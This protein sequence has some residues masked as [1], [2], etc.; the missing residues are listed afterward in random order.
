MSE[1]STP[2]PFD[3]ARFVAAQ[4]HDYDLA[5]AE[6]VRGRKTGHWIWYI[7]PQ[8]RGLGSSPLSWHYGITSIDEARAYLAHP[9]LGPRIRECSRM[10]AASATSSAD[11]YFGYPDNLK[12]RS[13]MSLFMRADPEEPAFRAVLDRYYRGRP[14]PRTDELLGIRAGPGTG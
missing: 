3:L 4:Q 9:V 12:V 13:S 5:L 2:D 6:L 8:L 14:D 10:I 11:A 1:G 7:L